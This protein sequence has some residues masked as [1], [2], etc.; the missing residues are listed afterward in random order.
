ME[1]QLLEH[2]TADRV[3]NIIYNQAMSLGKRTESG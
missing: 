1:I 3:S 2:G